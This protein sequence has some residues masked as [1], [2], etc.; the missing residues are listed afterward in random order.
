MERFPLIGWLPWWHP[1]ALFHVGR[2]DFGR[3]W[4]LRLF[5]KTLVNWPMP[6]GR[7]P[8]RWRYMYRLRFVPWWSW[9][10]VEIDRSRHGSWIYVFSFGW[11]LRG[12]G[13]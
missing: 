11:E 10:W 6:P 9:P 4:E 12:G 8:F 3:V 7:G 13:N 1:R 2:S 5:G